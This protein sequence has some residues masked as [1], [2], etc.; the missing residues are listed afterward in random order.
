MRSTRK[1][2]LVTV[3]FISALLLYL[4]SSSFTNSV[5]Y[6]YSVEE[7][8]SQ[9]DKLQDRGVRVNGKATGIGTERVS[10]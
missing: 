10:I 9:L 2:L 7:F 1:K 3:L 5:V 8:Q 4:M 6:Y